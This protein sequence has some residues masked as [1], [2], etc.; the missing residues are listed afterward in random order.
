M[1]RPANAARAG[2][3]CLASAQAGNSHRN[4]ECNGRDRDATNLPRTIDGASTDNAH[5]AAAR[6]VDRDSRRLRCERRRGGR[7]PAWRQ[8]DQHAAASRSGRPGARHLPRAAHIPRRSDHAVEHQLHDLL[9]ASGAPAYP[10]EYQSGINKYLEDLAHDSGGSQNVDSVATQYKDAAG[11]FA[12]YNSHFGGALIDT[13]P[14]PASGCSAATICFT[15]EQLR[16]EIKHYVEAHALPRDLTHE[17]FLL[18]PPEVE[19]CIE[20]TACSAGSKIPIYCAY[21]GN[22]PTPGG[23]LIYSNDPYVT[24]NSGCDN[25]EHPNN[26]PSDGALQGGLSHEHNESITDPELNAW[27]DSEG[28]ENGDKC[29]TG[30]EASE[31][32]TPLGRAPDGSRYNQIVNS[33]LY[34]YQQEWSNEGNQCKQRRTASAPALSVNKLEPTSG[35]KVGGTTVTITGTGFVPGKTVFRFG[36]TNATGVSCGSSTSCTAVSPKRAKVGKVDVVAT[37]AGKSSPKNPP[38]DQFTYV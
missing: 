32:G 9:G 16:A 3:A 29:R 33:D 30:E 23:V 17:Y 15:D 14:Y 31:F 18:T 35:P 11:E 21:H 37:V 13:D 1:R 26:K 4:L 24:G 34:W 28:N 10:A 36:G 6:P 7:A 5:R 2:D 27:T 12:N 20:L 22:I 38:A 25:G 19:D 8:G